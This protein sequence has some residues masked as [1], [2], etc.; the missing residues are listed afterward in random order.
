M[1]SRAG[2]FRDVEISKCTI[3]VNLTER[4][5]GRRGFTPVDIWDYKDSRGKISVLWWFFV[6]GV[7]LNGVKWR[8][9]NDSRSDVS[10]VRSSSLI[11]R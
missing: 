6:R 4:H 3:D 7:E 9:Y 11:S 10:G 8:Q 5:R 1:T 2:L